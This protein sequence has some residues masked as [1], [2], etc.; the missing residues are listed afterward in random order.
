MQNQQLENTKPVVNLPNPNTPDGL[1]LRYHY[2]IQSQFCQ[3][4]DQ[5]LLLI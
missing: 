4:K 5:F 1:S 3:T 2:E